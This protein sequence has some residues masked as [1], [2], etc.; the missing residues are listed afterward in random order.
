MDVKQAKQ[1]EAENVLGALAPGGMV[2]LDDMTPQEL[3]PDAWRGRRD[4]VREFWLNES[5]VAATEVRVTANSAVI[6]A[7]RIA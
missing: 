3:W 4:R 5:R 6:L 7:T 1:D 2:L